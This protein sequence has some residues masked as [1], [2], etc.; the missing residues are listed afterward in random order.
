MSGARLHRPDFPR[1]LINADCP[2][3][4]SNNDRLT[5]GPP[6]TAR[7]RGTRLQGRDG[8]LGDFPPSVPRFGVARAVGNFGL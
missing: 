6:R 8:G 4:P 5:R 2:F 3:F 7:L 1:R